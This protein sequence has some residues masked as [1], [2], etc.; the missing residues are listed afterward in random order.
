[1]SPGTTKG[2]WWFTLGLLTALTTMVVVLSVFTA[3]QR[4]QLNE[5]RT[6]LS[7]V[8][9]RAVAQDLA[10]RT[11]EVATCYASARGRPVL[12][13]VL[14]VLAGAA[15][16][17][18]DRAVVRGAIDVYEAGA[19][20]VAEC[21]QLARRKGLNPKDFPPPPVREQNGR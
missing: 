14:R 9:V 11:G 8:E 4:S 19:R 15:A 17:E 5:T 21:D 6:R 7:T 12:S 20:S 10:S 2:R 13:D 1:M 16:T 3:V 18:A